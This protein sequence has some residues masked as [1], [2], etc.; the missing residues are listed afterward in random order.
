MGFWWNIKLFF[1]SLSIIKRISNLSLALLVKCTVF[2]FFNKCTHLFLPIFCFFC[3]WT[4]NIGRIF[5]I[6]TFYQTNLVV[7][8]IFAE[9]REHSLWERFCMIVNSVLPLYRNQLINLHWKSM[10]WF[11]YNGQTGLK[12]VK[13]M[14]DPWNL[15]CSKVLYWPAYCGVKILSLL[16]TVFMCG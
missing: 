5:H 6:G 15:S 13:E 8:N 14:K 1:F 11:L 12:L 7:E 3:Y 4:S 16:I 2:L 10:N 9:L